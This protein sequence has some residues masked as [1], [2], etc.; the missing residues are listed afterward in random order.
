MPRL[1]GLPF[2]LLISPAI[3]LAHCEHLSRIPSPLS[4]NKNK[5]T[6]AEYSS[7]QSLKE[8]GSIQ[9][10]PEDKPQRKPLLTGPIQSCF[11]KLE[12]KPNAE[13]GIRRTQGPQA[14]VWSSLQQL[15]LLHTG[16]GD[17]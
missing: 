6:C 7:W 15:C 3:Q 11:N 2:H 1:S 5:T 13:S 12:K 14:Q 16:V 4:A 9:A 17:P 10:A 8:P